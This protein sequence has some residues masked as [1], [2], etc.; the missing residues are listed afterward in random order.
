MIFFLLYY[1]METYSIASHSADFAMSKAARTRF[2]KH[3]F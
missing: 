3:Q 1:V 2:K